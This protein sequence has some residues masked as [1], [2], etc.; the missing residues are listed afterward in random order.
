MDDPRAIAHY[1]I[2]REL[3]RGA[4]GVV[5]HAVDTKLGRPVAIKSLPADLATDVARRARFEQEARSL[6]AVNHP[7]IG[8][9]YGIEHQDDSLYL[10]L[11][12]VE[13]PTLADRLRD[14]PSPSIEEALDICRQVARGIDAA[15]QRGIIHRDLK[16]ENIKIR[17]D[18]V[19]KVLDFGIAMAGEVMS[20]KPVTANQGTIVAPAVTTSQTRTGFIMGTPGYM[21]PEQ[22]RGRAVNFAT[23]IWALGCILYECLTRVP[24]FPGESLADALAV[25]L[26]HEPDLRLLPPRTPARVL[27]T[28]RTCLQKDYRKRGEGLS[29]IAD[30][31]D[32]ALRDLAGGT[33][34]SVSL[35]PEDEGPP[36]PGNLP[37]EPGPIV[38]RTREL[39][40]AS[41][42]LTTTRLLT[43]CGPD[44]SGRARLALAVANAARQ[45]DQLWASAWWVRLPALGDPG[46]PARVAAF[47]LTATP[48]ADATTAL[49]ARIAARRILLL[50]E[51]CQHAPTAAATLAHDLL[52]ACP[53]LHIIATG[54][55]PLGLAGEAALAVGPLTGTVDHADAAKI[56]CDRAF[57][58]DPSQ[59]TQPL[60]AGA[61]V[62]L[63]RQLAGWPL[64]LEV[65]AGL[66]SMMPLT[67]IGPALDQRAREVGVAPLESQPPDVIHRLVISLALD[68]VP[69][70]ELGLLLQGS[71][72]VQ[73]FCVRALTAC[74]GARDVLPNP[75]SDEPSPT[76]LT[77]R[78]GRALTVLPR[79][80]ARGLLRLE[81]RTDD[82]AA[83]RVMLP[84]PVRQ[85]AIERL[86]ETPAAMAS[87]SAG[88]RAY[89]LASF[90]QAV[91]RWNGPGGGLWLTR[92]EE[93]YPELLAASL[94]AG[95]D[96]AAPRLQELVDAFHKRR[97]V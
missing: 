8:S 52:H 26:L 88:H 23:D 62:A 95:N 39:A 72:F 94:A 20:S 74:S 75:A 76:S 9:I 38:G 90:E 47:K 4:M 79:L 41:R 46:I 13:G 51:D 40:E 64:A 2:E 89:F 83:I 71:A 42:L 73:P 21:S 36:P 27:E 58:A 48:G 10:I 31:L 22:A 66:A 96:P 24:A 81:G 7:N 67:D 97:G 25:T 60:N 3:G 15:H 92:A 82:P 35:M 18:G 45:A 85:A 59:R 93:E 11:E 70:V 32:L 53:N 84:E 49:A 55:S 28:I 65:A 80:A 54:R 57:T 63:C 56:V 33:R 44:G 68:F 43:L 69:A 37:T 14:E 87:V 91:P 5:Y 77:P 78:E 50:L 30:A 12:Y 29:A 61:L 6:A 17:P 1:L 19:V 34:M 86:R 16:P